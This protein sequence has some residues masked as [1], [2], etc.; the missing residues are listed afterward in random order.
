MEKYDAR[1]DAYIAKS[2]DFAKPILKHLRELVHQT[3][4]SITETMKWGMPFFDYKGSVCQMAAF[5]EHM[6]FGFWK[7]KLLIDPHKILKPEDGTAGSF[8][9][10]KSLSDLPSDEIL[11]DFIWQ[12][13]RLNES[14]KVVPKKAPAEKKELLP[15]DYFIAALNTN[16]V[17]KNTYDNF[18]YTNKKDYLQWLDEAKTEATRQKRLETTLEWLAEGKPR[19]W[20]YMK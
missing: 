14:N 1:I 5:K 8:G 3:A 18:S 6:G 17:A 10:I 20:K 15:P 7:E 13:I 4:P 12:G 2:A 19:M 16:P 9:P 11:A